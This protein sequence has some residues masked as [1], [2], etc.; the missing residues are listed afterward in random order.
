MKFDL[1]KNHS[2]LTSQEGMKNLIVVYM[3][4]LGISQFFYGSISVRYGRRPAIVT[5]FFISIIGLLLSGCSEN[6]IFM[7]FTILLF[8]IYLSL[9]FVL[10][11]E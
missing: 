4:I 3:V 9:V 5:G 10:Q 6:N 11:R 7:I 8:T 2:A 1:L